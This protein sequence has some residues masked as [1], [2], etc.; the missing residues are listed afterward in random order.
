[1]SPTV[2]ATKTLRRLTQDPERGQRTSA[3]RHNRCSRWRG[4]H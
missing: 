4:T 3:K 2:V 1:M